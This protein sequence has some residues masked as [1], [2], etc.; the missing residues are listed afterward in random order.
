M[1]ARLSA[2]MTLICGAYAVV[3]AAG[4]NA[5][6]A[7]FLGLAAGGWFINFVDGVWP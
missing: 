1:S 4:G 7:A 2:A 6:D 5:W 3:F